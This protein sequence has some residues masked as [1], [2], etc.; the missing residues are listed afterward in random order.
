MTGAMGTDP[1]DD[2][3]KPGVT[4]ADP[5]ALPVDAVLDTGPLDP[6]GLL[7]QALAERRVLVELCLYALDRARSSG[8]A[9]RIEHGLASIGV[10]AL[11]P[12]GAA[13]DPTRHEAGGTVPT[14]DRGLHGL[15]AETEV[16]G[17]TDHGRVLRVPVVTVYQLRPGA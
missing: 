9:Q 7:T 4:P 6:Y 16:T 8:V 13:F 17:F 12:D 3:S 11:R 15:V 5:I 2:A 1:F 10:R 14:D